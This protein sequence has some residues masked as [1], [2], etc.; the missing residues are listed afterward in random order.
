MAVNG[1]VVWASTISLPSARAQ[2]TRGSQLVDKTSWVVRG[3]LAAGRDRLVPRWSAVA[4]VQHSALALDVR[5]GQGGTRC[6]VAAVT[7]IAFS[8]LQIHRVA[9]RSFLSLPSLQRGV[10]TSSR[11]RC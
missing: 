9:K 4:A 11:Y 1:R 7:P 2:E 3:Q 6:L 5:C 8:A 10:A